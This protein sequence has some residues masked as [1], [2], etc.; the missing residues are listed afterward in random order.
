[1]QALPDISSLPILY[2]NCNRGLVIEFGENES[3]GYGILDDAAVLSHARSGKN[4]S[5]G[6]EEK[7]ITR[8]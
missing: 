4:F 7:N 2:E 5:I 6:L 8:G 1:M 3:A